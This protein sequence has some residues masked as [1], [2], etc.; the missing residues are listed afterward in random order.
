MGVGKRGSPKS[1]QKGSPKIPPQPLKRTA[2]K[3][4]T[5]KR[6]HIAKEKGSEIWG[7]AYL[8][9]L[10]PQPGKIGSAT[11]IPNSIQL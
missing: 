4:H 2:S 10:V 3:A 5:A 11:H 9:S 7:G 6:S 8:N 1:S